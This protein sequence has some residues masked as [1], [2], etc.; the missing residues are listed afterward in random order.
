MSLGDVARQRAQYRKGVLLG[1]TV[2]EAM[3][4]ILFALLL[5]LGALL[6]R[7]D[8]DVAKLA[9][10]LIEASSQRKL[11]ET[12]AEVLQ[13]IVQNRPT[14][15]FI[16]ELVLARELQARLER[17]EKA[18]QEREKAIRENVQLAEALKDAT[19]P[20]QKLRELAAL[21]G[22]LEA[23]IAKL[24]PEAAKADH[25]DLVPEGV[26][27]AEAASR[28]SNGPAD[29]KRALRDAERVTRENATLKGQ[30]VRFRKEL[31]QIGRGGEY[32]PCW[33][34][35]T[36]DIQYI[37]DIDMNGDGAFA[38]RDVTPPARLIDRRELSISSALFAGSVSPSNF[39]TLTLP[40][41]RYGQNNNCR[42]VVIARDRTGPSQ[43]DLFKNLLLTVEGHFYKS[44]RR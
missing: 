12:R 14:D 28:T 38:V 32:P 36:G 7:K 23:E 21:G 5:A 39:T 26:A 16:R 31:A 11:A 3:L 19:N 2:A 43:K 13:A 29:A 35:E 9:V 30:V 8:R 34:T 18:L 24:S 1:L 17:E 33:V 37:L 15:E 42:F 40:L 10:Q 44:L 4:L 25:F 6:T 20:R 41:Y 22:R 27:L